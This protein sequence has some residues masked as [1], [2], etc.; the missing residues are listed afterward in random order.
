MDDFRGTDPVGY[1]ACAH[2][3]RSIG[4][5]GNYRRDAEHQAA[6]TGLQSDTERI[7]SA[8]DDRNNGADGAPMIRDADAFISACKKSGFNF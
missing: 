3:A 8:I 1:E 6:E 4:A 5:G 2:Y 7:R